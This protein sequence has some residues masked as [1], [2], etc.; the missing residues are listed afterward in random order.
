MSRHRLFGYLAIGSLFA[1][2]PFAYFM[3]SE[4]GVAAVPLT[5]SPSVRE[6]YWQEQIEVLGSKRAYAAFAEAVSPLTPGKRH[7]NAHTFGAALYAAEGKEGLAT[8]DAQF[9]YGCFHEFLG[10]AIASLGLGVVYELNQKCVDALGSGALSCQHGIGHG[11]LAALGYDEDAFTEALKVCKNIPYSDPIG[12]CYGGLFMEFNMQ[13]MLGEAG[14]IRQPKN[15]N[16]LDPCDRLGPEYLP[17]CAF[18]SPQWWL[19]LQHVERG[20]GEIDFSKI[21]PLCDAFGTPAL[22]RACYEGAGTVAPP[23]ADFDP[24]KAAALCEGTSSDRTRQ[25]YCKSYAANSIQLGGSGQTGDG[26]M[27]CA[28]LPERELQYC[29]AYAMNEAN[30]LE[31]LGDI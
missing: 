4:H 1:L 14:H 7:D 19:Q 6:A 8:C 21:G 26:L 12:G 25:L 5:G 2:A 16:L 15:G 24:K 11:V 30:L 10:R 20:A 9:S 3:L 17:A 28:G 13:T 27:V 18:W 29:H 23:E 31:Q 22:V